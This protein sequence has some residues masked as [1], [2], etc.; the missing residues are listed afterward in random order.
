MDSD[1]ETL[2]P[3]GP[4]FQ[5]HYDRWALPPGAT[6]LARNP[7]ASQAFV[8]RRNLALQFHPELT[9]ASLDGWL[10]NGGAE[11]AAGQGIDVS[12]LIARTSALAPDAA[13]RAAAL[14]DGF[15]RQI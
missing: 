8:L 3:D 10:E 15:L 11:E 1:D 2:V 14:V 12:S 13:R 4:W 7:A 5:W 9:A 6:E